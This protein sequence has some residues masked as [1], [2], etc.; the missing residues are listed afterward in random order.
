MYKLNTSITFDDGLQLDQP[1]WFL[2][3]V[4]DD[5]PNQLV[6]VN[7]TFMV[8]GGRHSRPMLVHDYSGPGTWEDVE[9]YAALLALPELANSYLL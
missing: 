4:N 9:L 7:V 8:E 1:E 3:I 6:H 5:I 2:S